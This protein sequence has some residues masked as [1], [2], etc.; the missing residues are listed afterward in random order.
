MIPAPQF[1]V[2]GVLLVQFGLFAAEQEYRVRLKLA[3]HPTDTFE[4]PDVHDTFITPVS[5]LRSGGS[6]NPEN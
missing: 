3:R 5:D 4:S 2:H 6:A 1:K